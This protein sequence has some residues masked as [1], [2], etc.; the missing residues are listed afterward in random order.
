MNIEDSYFITCE[1]GGNRIPS[2]YRECFRGKEALLHSHRGCDAGALRLAR[3]LSE[4]LSAPLLVSTVS[5][6][7]VDLNRSQHHSKL[8]SEATRPLSHELRHEILTRYYL[9]YR[10]KAEAA[11]EQ[12]IA[13]GQRVIHI[14][15]HSFTPEIDGKVRNA[16]IGLLYDPAREEEA[17]LCRRW[18]IALK[19]YTAGLHSRMNYPYAGTSDGFTVYLRK[20]FPAERYLGI[21]LEINQKHVH[22]GAAHWHEVRQV[23]IDSL[24]AVIR[25]MPFSTS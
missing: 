13:Y 20:R 1:H 21:E 11:I 4:A 12:A 6:L 24:C 19:E 10:A 8:F 3:E 22:E 18:Q 9:P 17:K 15:S 23:V 7:L 25:P 16:D 14:S 5:R 2:R